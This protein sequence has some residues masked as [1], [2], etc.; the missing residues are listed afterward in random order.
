MITFKKN[1]FSTLNIV[2]CYIRAR[3]SNK[4]QS[5]TNIHNTVN[6]LFSASFK[7]SKSLLTTK[8]FRIH[9]KE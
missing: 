4:I 8:A 1:K 3:A 9:R 6:K 2:F 7:P 5:E